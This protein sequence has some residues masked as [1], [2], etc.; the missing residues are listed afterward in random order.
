MQV[1]GNFCKMTKSVMIGLLAMFLA[2]SV[3]WGQMWSAGTNVTATLA[4]GVLTISG[5]GAMANYAW[6]S[7]APWVSYAN[8]IT[9]VVIEEGVT[10]I[11]D[12]A[13]T[14]CTGLTEVTSLN[15]TPIAN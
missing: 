8:V 4:D 12:W 11:G 7:P 15:P 9:S 3:S 6:N 13:F 10:S 1:F 5:T 2:A 14:G